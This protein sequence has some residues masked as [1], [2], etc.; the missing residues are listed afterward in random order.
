MLK[1]DTLLRALLRQPTPYTPV[2]VMRQAGR[3][4]PEYNATRKRA[5]SFL[6]L[7]KNPDLATEVTLQP[8]ARFKLDAAILFSDI[9]TVPDAMGLGLYFAEG[10]GPKF[11]RPLRDETAIRKLAVPDPGASLAY[12]LDAVKQIRRALDNS[13]P[14]IGFSGSPYTLACY[15]IEGGGSDDFRTIK[16]MLYARPDL[17]HHV[18]DINARAVI[19]YLNAQIEAGAQAVMVFDTWGGSLSDAAYREFSLEYLRRVITGIHREWDGQIIPSIAAIGCNAVGLDWTVNLGTARRRIGDKVALQGN[20]DPMVLF[21]NPA[22][23][24]TQVDAVLRQ[25]GQGSGHVFNLG[26]GIS[27]FTPPEHVAALVDAVHDL[28]RQYH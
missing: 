26:H 17:L 18:L 2:W 23:I 6:A 27:Q 3:Y 10:E 21:S 15:M 22:A 13:V 8:L 14:L 12:V 25:F 28:S 1:N 24:N 16:S 20:L 9:L 5:G 11:E 19:A 4:L 7:A